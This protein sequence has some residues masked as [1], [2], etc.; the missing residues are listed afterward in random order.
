MVT[1]AD[2]QDIQGASNVLLT[3]RE[4]APK[5]KIAPRTLD[6]WMRQRRIPF[7]KIGKSVRFRLDDV[8][9]QLSRYRV[10]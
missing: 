5:L 2:T 10:N 8:L 4:L 3:K 7:L 1:I 9:T 6:L